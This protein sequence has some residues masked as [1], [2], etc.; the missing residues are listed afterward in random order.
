MD[1]RQFETKV[2]QLLTKRKMM[3]S[4]K[5]GLKAWCKYFMAF[6]WT[7]HTKHNDGFE[8]IDI[9]L[10]DDKLIG[11]DLFNTNFSMPVADLYPAT[12]KNNKTWQHLLPAL[13]EFNGKGLGIGEL[14][15]AL[16][17]RGWTFERKDGKGDGKVAGGT[18]E[19]K[20]IGASLKPLNAA[21]APPNK[22]QDE[23]NETVF[24]GHRAGPITKFAEHRAWIETQPDIKAVY[25]EYFTKLYP[26]QYVADMVKKLA[27]ETDGQKFNNIIGAEVIKWYKEIDGFDSL[28]IIDQEK[29][30]ITNIAD[31]TDLSM[32][33]N[34]RFDWKSE[35]KGD[36]QAIADGYVNI[37]I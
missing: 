35:R 19:V 26:G 15:F 9:L 2:N 3:P 14:Y 22:Y 33:K 30:L 13:I 8:M 34:I 7:E 10:D 16:V 27:V 20:K 32:F 28:I 17:I 24:Q 11:G 23:L 1:I 4:K 25:M 37:K 36:K 5:I 21:M 6:A 12:L 29:M 18:R 31:V